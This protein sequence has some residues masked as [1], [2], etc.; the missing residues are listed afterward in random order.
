MKIHKG[1]TI[2]LIVALIGGAALFLPGYIPTHDGEF[3]IIRIWQFAKVLGDGNLIPRW[4]PDLNS[5]YGVPLFTFYYPLPY[6]IG[7]FFHFLGW[8]LVDSFKLTLALALLGTTF[9]SFLWL[10]KLFGLTSAVIGTLV[11]LSTPYLWVDLYVRGSVG[12]VLAIMWAIAV[13]ASVEHK[14][15]RL[16]AFAVAGLILSHNIIAMLF[17]P[18]LIAYSSLRNKRIITM[19]VWGLMVSA[20]FWVP[21]LIERQ[22]VEGLSNFDFRDHFISVAQ[23]IIPSWGT[24]FSRAGWP[25][26]EMSQQLGVGVL[27]SVL[28]A[29]VTL[30]KEREQIIKKLLFGAFTVF[31]ITCALLIEQSIPLWQSLAPLRVIQYPWRFLSFFVPLGALFAGYAAMRLKRKWIMVVLVGF[32]FLIS[33]NYMRP[34]VYEPRSD[35]YY[36]SRREFTDGTTTVGNSFSTRWAPWR[37]ERPKERVERKTGDATVSRLQ[38]NA[39][40]YSFDLVVHTQSMLRIHVNYYPGWELFINKQPAR[41]QEADGMIAFGVDPGNHNVQLRFRETLLRKVANL[42]SILGLFWLLVSAILDQRYAYRYRHYT[43][44]NRS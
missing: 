14:K 18:V 10:R 1:L 28:L 42:T 19:F 12:E 34:V 13:L 40:M 32:A 17:F 8:S 11:L 7:S 22:Y 35:A 5:T 3:S 43:A 23:L 15:P 41:V 39:N 38:E 4:A 2:V 26:D 16:V 33:F 9:F 36:L 24:G 37:K 31:G 29:F 27:A 44:S 25:A 30:R 21:A 6:V 20:Y